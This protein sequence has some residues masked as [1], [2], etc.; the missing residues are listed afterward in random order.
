MTTVHSMVSVFNIAD[1]HDPADTSFV[2]FGPARTA[3]F[4]FLATG[5]WPKM[6]NDTLVSVYEPG[7]NRGPISDPYTAPNGP[8]AGDGSV[9]A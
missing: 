4:N 1:A 9:F 3:E 8:L 5:N 2:V 6:T 7:S